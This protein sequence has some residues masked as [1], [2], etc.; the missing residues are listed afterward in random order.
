MKRIAT[1]CLAVL[2]LSLCFVGCSTS[3]KTFTAEGMSITLTNRFSKLSYAGFTA[4][5]GASDVA[6]FALKEEFT[7]VGDYTLDE[8]AALVIDVNGL[9]GVTASTK[10]GLTSFLYERENDGVNYTYFATVH[11][12]QDAFWLIQFAVES[13]DYAKKEADILEYA[14]SISFS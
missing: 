10:D 1:L 11:K 12:T 3:P 9:E 7:L 5:Y 13:K 6:V 8:Y 2:L 4:V 14:K